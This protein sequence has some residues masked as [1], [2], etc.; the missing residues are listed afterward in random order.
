[1]T[2]LVTVVSSQP[3]FDKTVSFASST[4]S[5]AVDLGGQ[6][7]IGVVLPDSF[8]GT[9][10]TVHAPTEYTDGKVNDDSVYEVV[11]DPE[12]NDVSFTVDSADRHITFDSSLITKMRSVRHL[13]LVGTSQTATVVLVTA[14]I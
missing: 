8:S 5:T 1:M 6:T 7:L 10:L 11:K 3:N 12:G 14:V 13:K 4:T 9:T 2:T